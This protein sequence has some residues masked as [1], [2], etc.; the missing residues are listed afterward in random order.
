MQMAKKIS[1]VNFALTENHKKKILDTASRYSYTVDFFADNEEAVPYLADSE[2]IYGFGRELAEAAKNLKWFC[3]Y[4]A[5]VDI[6]LSLPVFQEKSAIL[7]NSS[8]AYGITMAEHTVMV[9]LELLRRQMEYLEIVRDRQWVRTLPIHSVQGSRITIM[10][11]GDIGRQ[12]AKRLQGFD[13]A[14]IVGINRSGKNCDTYF[15]KVCSS[16]EIDQILP[17]TD[18]LIMCLPGTKETENLMSAGR[19]SLLPHHAFLINVGRGS[20]VDQQAL[21]DMLERNELAGA[22]LDVFEHEPLLPDDPIWN[23]NNLLITPHIAGNLTLGQTIDLT[24]DFFCEDLEN[25]CSGRPLKRQI[26]LTVGY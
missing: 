2:I 25:Y 15:D 14:H 21:T 19:L 18:I 9:T 20:S 7:S 10:G 22:A 13:P 11:T 17:E 12:I 26:D 6:Y 3:S 23:C 16:D 1:V 8:G 24:T 5:G 4:S